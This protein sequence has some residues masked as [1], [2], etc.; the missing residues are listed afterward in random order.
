MLHC[1]CTNDSTSTVASL[2]CSDIYCKECLKFIFFRVAKYGS[3]FPPACHR[4]P[5]DIST[6]EADLS[7]DEL[8]AYRFAEQKFT[9]M[10]KV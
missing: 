7:V 4:Q 2:A 5:I 9:S 3:L 6:V 1:P 10:T 8:K